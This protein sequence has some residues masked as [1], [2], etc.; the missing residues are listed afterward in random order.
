MF[1]RVPGMAKQFGYCCSWL[2]VLLCSFS[3][4]QTDTTPIRYI[5]TGNCWDLIGIW[6]SYLHIQVL[7]NNAVCQCLLAISFLCAYSV[8]LIHLNLVTR[9]SQ[10]VCLV[11]RHTDGHTCIRRFNG[12]RRLSCY[13]R[14]KFPNSNRCWLLDSQKQLS[15]STKQND[16]TLRSNITWQILDW[17]WGGVGWG[18]GLAQA[19]MARDDC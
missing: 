14:L 5:K 7:R 11:Y 6:S 2:Q 19:T 3:G 8:V 1:S 18:W 9:R 13:T 15:M 17:G 16:S 12:I 10:H 4:P